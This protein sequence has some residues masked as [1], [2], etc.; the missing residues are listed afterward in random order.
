MKIHE[1]DLTTFLS[2]TFEAFWIG[3]EHEN[4]IL[5]LQE[6]QNNPHKDSFF[7]E[8][9]EQKDSNWKIRY[10]I[11]KT[12]KDTFRLFNIMESLKWI[13]KEINPSIIEKEILLTEE[14][15]HSIQEKLNKVKI[16]IP[17]NFSFPVR[18]TLKLEFNESGKGVC[19]DEDKE[20]DDSIIKLVN[21]LKNKT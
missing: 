9:L 8:L 11:W 15:K 12:G 5:L 1:L 17:I 18:K 7:I 10:S 4:R 3:K 6:W 19:W 20:I 21:E 16:D 14:E 13:G 2:K